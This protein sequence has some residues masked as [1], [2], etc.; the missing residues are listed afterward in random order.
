MPT[1]TRDYLLR[2]M[3]E[4]INHIGYAVQ[5]LIRIAEIYGNVHPELQL[6]CKQITTP[7]EEIA[8][9]MIQFKDERM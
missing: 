2:Y 9:L 6:T 4:A 3:D 1:R 5:N 8:L 7:L